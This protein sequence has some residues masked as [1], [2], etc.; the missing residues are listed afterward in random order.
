MAHLSVQK[1]SPDGLFFIDNLERCFH[2]HKFMQ[3][4]SIKLMQNIKWEKLMLALYWHIEAPSKNIHEKRAIG[5]FVHKK[6]W[7]EKDGWRFWFALNIS[8]SFKQMYSIFYIHT[9]E[10]ASWF[11]LMLSQNTKTVYIYCIKQILKHVL[12]TERVEPWSDES[13]FVPKEKRNGAFALRLQKVLFTIF[14]MHISV[15]EFSVFMWVFL[16]VSFS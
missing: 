10:K 5:S 2:L 4:I 8:I 7:T 14:I 1:I 11:L 15:Y 6:K 12:K 9:W 13:L 16:P 3:N